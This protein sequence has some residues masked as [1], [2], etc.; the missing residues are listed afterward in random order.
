MYSTARTSFISEK[1]TANMAVPP[2]KL[3]TREDWYR[4]RNLIKRLYV[5][6]QKTL[7]QVMTIMASEHRMLATYV[8][9][10]IISSPAC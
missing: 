5:D 4:H 7:K 10:L 3:A 2:A 8:F 9:H 6:E 1:G